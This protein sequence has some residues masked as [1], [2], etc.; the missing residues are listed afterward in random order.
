MIVNLFF[1]GIGFCAYVK[2]SLRNDS[3]APECPQDAL[4]NAWRGALLQFHGKTLNE[5]D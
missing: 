2:K 4:H 3:R 1:W 5:G